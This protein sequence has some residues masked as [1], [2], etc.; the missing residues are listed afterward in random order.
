MYLPS[1]EVCVCLCLCAFVRVR[2]R[3]H[4]CVCARA[5]VFYFYFI[6]LYVCVTILYFQVGPD[7]DSSLLK[8]RA[9][10]RWDAKKKR[11]IKVRML[12]YISV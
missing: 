11:F 3:A 7:E 2:A 9:V 12:A 5:P 10:M 6:I 1:F 4:L 8:K